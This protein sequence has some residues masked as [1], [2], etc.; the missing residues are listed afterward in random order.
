METKRCAVVKEETKKIS[1]FLAKFAVIFFLLHTA[2]WIAD[3][4]SLENY[5]AGI[6]AKASSLNSEQNKIFVQGEQAL[7]INA[8]CTGL[9]SISILAGIVFAFRK[10]ELKKKLLI[11]VPSALL[12]FFLNMGRL[13]LVVQTA[14]A[15]GLQAGEIVHEISWIATA[16]FII[17]L[18]YYFTLKATKSKKFNELL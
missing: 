8:S 9:I 5:L 10:P 1:L 13:F 3:L 6:E 18:W 11:F 7:S 4:S 16:V 15:Y 12:L 14:K 17:L 2:I